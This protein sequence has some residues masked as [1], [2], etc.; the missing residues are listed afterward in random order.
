[1]R[2]VQ[3]GDTASAHEITLA[4]AKVPVVRDADVVVVGGGPGGFAAALRAA[5]M[6]AST[7][8]IEKHDMPGGV[9]TI[10]LQGAAS[11]GVGGIHSELMQRFADAGCIYTV[12]EA[13]LPDWA[14]NPLSHYE[15]YL[16]PG[17]AF[18]RSSFNPES[19]GCVMVRMLEEAGVTALYGT[20]FVDTVVANG[21]I[22]QVIVENASGTQ[23][24][25]GKVFIDGSG[26]AEVSARAGV[27]FVRGGG[28]QPP[29]AQWDGQHRPIPGALLWIMSGIDFAGVA[30]YQKRDNDP[31]LARLIGAA[32]SAGDI[33]ENL[34]R[35]RMGGEG[36]YG[37]HY[38]GH[39]TLD[40]SPMQGPGT[41]VFWQNV[42]YEWALHMDDNAE[43]AAR[44]KRAL[45]E[46]IDAEARFAKKYVPGFENAFISNVGRYVGVRDGRHPM[47]E[48]QFTID[49]ARAS[50][51][52]PDAIS[53]PMTKTFFWD[54][55]TAYTFE[56]PY[57]CFLPKNID[58]LLLTGASLSFAYETIFMVM[59]NFPWCTQTGEIAGYAAGLAVQQG[60]APKN[61]EWTTPY[62]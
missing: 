41:F 37:A 34:Y 25:R 57:R 18:T 32:R 14:G 1:M 56:I 23:A 62:F 11:R 46:F 31:T 5:R 24:I 20:S 40:M 53:K 21:R 54:T 60:I 39:P 61:L 13:T 36:V 42:P 10:G 33:P 29:K 6:G 28:P 55:H 27:P 3:A 12:T 51:R 52:F 2:P 9:H 59:R 30:A 45:R 19:A 7:V 38:I 8:L 26:T 35:P 50:R 44:A 58:N 15:A 22:N 48:Y 16:K 49:D 43:D 4:P 47:A 17:S